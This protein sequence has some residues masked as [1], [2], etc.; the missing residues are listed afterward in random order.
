MKKLVLLLL[1]SLF[2]IACFAGQN[3]VLRVGIHPDPPFIIERAPGDY[4]GLC[5]DLWED[6]AGELGY[7]Y[8]IIPYHDL[9]GMMR[10]LDYQEIDIS[11]NPWMVNSLRLKM[12]E[13]LQPFFISSLGVATTSVS[14]SQFQM[15]L[16]NFFSAD[17]LKI[18]LLLM[19][20]IFFFGTLLWL[21]ERRHNRYQFRPGF[22]GLVDGLWWS[23]VTMTTVGYGDKA[24]KTSVGKGIAIVWM[25]TAVIVISG[26]T[27]TIASTLTVNSL[28]V[29]I[30]E[31][32]DLKSVERLGTVG[33]TGSEDFLVQHDLLPTASY[34]TPL[35]AIEALARKEVD[36]LVYDKTVMRYLISKHDLN[37]KVQLLPVTFNKQ[38]RTFLLPK[39]SPLYEAI[40]PVLV[41]RI[42]QAD[43]PEVLKRYELEGEE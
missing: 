33:S 13:A 40:N 32:Q 41:S 23:A 1:F 37:S 2:A 16:S 11:I 30:N 6:I 8:E 4:E 5:I 17:F 42:H 22:I 38:Y 9:V 20:I 7:E 3:K 27:A 34:D 29:Q 21:V 31:L 25:F 12:F 18:V 39:G 36:A 28:A 43:W 24:P 14:R 35:R 26:F 19:C 15:F 10:A